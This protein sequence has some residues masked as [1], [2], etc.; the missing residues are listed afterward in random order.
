[1]VD[2][3]EVSPSEIE[4]MDVASNPELQKCLDMQSSVEAEIPT[5]EVVRNQF[6]LVALFDYL[7][8]VEDR[9]I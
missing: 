9:Q 8:D 3:G 6:L 5:G 4:A 1:M 2:E 7:I